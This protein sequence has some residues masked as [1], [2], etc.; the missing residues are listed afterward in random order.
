VCSLILCIRIEIEGL[1]LLISSLNED[2]VIVLFPCVMSCVCVF[3]SIEI[4]GFGTYTNELVH[5]GSYPHLM[6]KQT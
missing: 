6:K 4:L 3:Q 2:M 1:V 5:I